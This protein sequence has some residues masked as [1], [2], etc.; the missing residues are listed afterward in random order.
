MTTDDEW[1]DALR[2]FS[3]AAYPAGDG[4]DPAFVVRAGRRRKTARRAAGTA[5]A[6]A[7]VTALALGVPP[8]LDRA[9]HP[10]LPITTPG[11]V[12]PSTSAPP[13]P[14]PT[15]SSPYPGLVTPPTGPADAA[16]IL[17]GE[18][19]T[20][21]DVAGVPVSI[22]GPGDGTVLPI[23]V[24][25]TAYDLQSEV[26]PAYRSGFG[27]WTPGGAIDWITEP[28]R[29]PELGAETV[30]AAVSAD[31]IVWFESDF[32]NSYET[33]Y[34][35]WARPRSGGTA[36]ELARSPQVPDVAW[37]YSVSDHHP[38]IVGGTLFWVDEVY[39]G[40]VP[41]DVVMAA[42]LDGSRPATVLVQ[43][44]LTLVPDR[45]SADPALFVVTGKDR[46]SRQVLHRIG[47][48]ADGSVVSD[49][50]IDDDL[51]GTGEDVWAVTACGDTV[52]V[53]HDIDWESAER[54]SWLE[55]RKAGVPAT[56]I[57][58][59]EGSGS[60][61]GDFVPGPGF[62]TWYAYNGAYNGDTYLYD[63]TDQTLHQFASQQ[64]IRTD[65]TF[66]WWLQRQ[67]E[68]ATSGVAAARISGR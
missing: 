14:S 8:L 53:A 7:L 28:P 47:L 13:S 61:L 30:E 11:P 27:L 56:S 33:P 1:A 26:F 55:I 19:T 2:A 45:C 37:P 42:P 9:D 41:V 39:E 17:F 64:A 65:G 6:C 18:P 54:G 35:L 32:A 16:T 3:C 43:N 60:S 10:T 59:P 38:V 29:T 48:A 20:P 12:T 49:R 21:G 63:L 44:A 15:P 4:P 25:P 46:L 5:T 57:V 34:V 36:R 40:A 24:T 50:T 62:V 51:K 58:W 31:W 68:S 23:A 52:F 66:V 22:I 67:P